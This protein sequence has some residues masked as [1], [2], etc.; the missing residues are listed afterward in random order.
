METLL[1]EDNLQLFVIF[2]FPG[3]VS[4]HMYRLLMPAREVQW[5]TAIF[6]GIFYSI[7]NFAIC[8]P[9]LITITAES[10]LEN[11]K[12][13]F[14]L[15]SLFVLL[16]GPSIWPFALI[17]LLKIPKLTKWF[18]LPYPTAWDAFF[19]RRQQCFMIIHLK[20]GKSI[21]G[22]YGP[23]SYSTSFPR[24]GDLYLSAV[25]KLDQNGKFEGPSVPNTRG[26]LIRKNEYSYIELFDVPQQK[27]GGQNNVQ[28]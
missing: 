18:Q 16:I 26:L 23:T 15:G 21:A 17:K 10:F 11:H 8:L 13:W 12:G 22:Y 24:D 1:T 4:M 19:D 7:I 25:Y 5:S 14:M 3:L 2:V 20:N 27:K 6:E 9:I 28:G